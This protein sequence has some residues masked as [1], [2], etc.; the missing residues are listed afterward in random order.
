MKLKAGFLRNWVLKK[1]KWWASKKNR[2][3]PV[4]DHSRW[5][6]T[7][8]PPSAMAAIERSTKSH[9][10]KQQKNGPIMI[11]SRQLAYLRKQNHAVSPVLSAI[12]CLSRTP[13]GYSEDEEVFL[14]LGFMNTDM[15]LGQWPIAQWCSFE[16]VAKNIT[17]TQ[18]K[19]T[20]WSYWPSAIRTH[21]KTQRKSATTV[22]SQ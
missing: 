20:A 16:P 22:F 7:R 12:S 18:I 15:G 1:K 9:S 17:P 6:I 2:S 4:P 8:K 3:S 10:E 11:F 5:Q 14:C 19:K 13:H 21:A